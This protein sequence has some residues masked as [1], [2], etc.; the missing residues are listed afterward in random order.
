MTGVYVFVAWALGIVVG[1]R[2]GRSERL[3]D[4]E[5]RRQTLEGHLAW[6]RQDW[7]KKVHERLRKL[8]RFEGR[9]GA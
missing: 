2:M 1:V 7:N 3:A 4:L 5:Y 9:R 6:R 8:H